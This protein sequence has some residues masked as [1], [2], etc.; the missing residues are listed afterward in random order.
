[1]AEQSL[2]DQHMLGIVRIQQAGVAASASDGGA[3]QKRPGAQLI[4]ITPEVDEGRRR[5][6]PR[7]P[8]NCRHESSARFECGD[9]V[10]A[11]QRQSVLLNCRGTVAVSQC[12]AAVLPKRNIVTIAKINSSPM[13]TRTAAFRTMSTRVLRSTGH[14][15]HHVSSNCCLLRVVSAGSLALTAARNNGAGPSTIGRGEGG[16]G[17]RYT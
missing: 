2:F 6:T 13:K 7:L 3:D 15:N 4:T 9:S 16:T 11:P 12:Y 17:Q 14:E 10:L 5:G 1:M 8:A